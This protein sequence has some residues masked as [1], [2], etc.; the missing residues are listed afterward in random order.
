MTRNGI[1]GIPV[2]AVTYRDVIVRARESV[3]NRKL[4][5]IL[6]MNP[7]KIM[8]ALSSP[9]LRHLL[10]QADLFIPDGIGI[11]V[12]GR[13]QG[14]PFPERVTGADLLGE[15]VQ[16]AARSGWKIYLLGA[17]PGVADETVRI[18]LE[19]YPGLQVAGV[20]DGY[21]STDE[22]EQVAAGIEAAAPEMLFVAMGSPRQEQFIEKYGKTMN[23]PVVMGVGGSFDVVSGRVDR[24]P[25]WMQ[26]VGMEWTW[27]LIKEPRRILRM[28]ALPRFMVLVLKQKFGLFAPEEEQK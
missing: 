14:T 21:F 4:F 24:A 1:L 17:A 28:A 11:L 6:A 7:E 22:E 3:S 26:K 15:L 25:V 18:W 12:A 16:E 2:D 20:R 27:R 13:L 8:K 5:W 19:K 10:L 23:V 9:E